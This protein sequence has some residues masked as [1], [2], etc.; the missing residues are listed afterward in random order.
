MTGCQPGDVVTFCVGLGRQFLNHLLPTLLEHQGARVSGICDLQ[1]ERV[2]DA[3]SR[4]GDQ[5]RMGTAP[6]GF[7][8]FDRLLEHATSSSTRPT[9]FVISTPPATH[10]AIVEKCLERGHHVYVDKPLTTEHSSAVLVTQLARK[11]GVALVVGSQ[12]RFESIF[13]RLHDLASDVGAVHR[14]HV[15]AHGRFAQMDPTSVENDIIPVGIGYHMLDTLCWLANGLGG[16]PTP[17]PV[18]GATLRRAY[19][20]PAQHVALEALL[21][22]RFSERTVPV[23][24]TCSSLAPPDSVDELIVVSGRDGEVQYRR[25]NAPRGSDPGV[26]TIAMR[27]LATS[28]TQLHTIQAQ[29][30]AAR[31]APLAGLLDAVV[32]NTFTDLVSTGNEALPTLALIEA[33]LA[34]AEDLGVE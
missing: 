16:V 33:I 24:F 27:D 1:Q 13:L 31:G 7:T 21:A 8:N 17:E 12:R 26:I 20:N 29:S 3:L 9:V 10:A 14:L 4:F 2:K 32:A 5:V 15:H 19:D 6:C 28:T 22:F 25:L 34:K 11:Q 30:G 23:T 18:V